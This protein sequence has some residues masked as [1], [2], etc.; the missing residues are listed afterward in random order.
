MK[1]LRAREGERK[2]PL[3]FVY[4]EKSQRTN[5]NPM[6]LIRNYSKVI[7]DT[8]NIQKSTAS[9]YISHENWNLKLKSQYHL[10]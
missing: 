9:L 4:V 10:Q 3:F 1:A 5:K 7:G 6:E 2:L 8:V